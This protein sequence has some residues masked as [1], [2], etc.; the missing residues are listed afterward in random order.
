VDAMRFAVVDSNGLVVNV[1]EAPD[2]WEVEGHT[3]VQTDVG[4]PG[5]TY[6]AQAEA[7]TPVKVVSEP[8]AREQYEAAATPAERMAI[9][10][11]EL[12]LTG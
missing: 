11:K 4:G 10:A 7:F 2:D 6:D 3:F 5:D 1:I 9:L 12:G 8:S